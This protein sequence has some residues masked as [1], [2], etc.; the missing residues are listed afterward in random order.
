MTRSTCQP[1]R[2]AFRSRAL[3]RCESNRPPCHV[4]WSTSTAHRASGSHAS[5]WMSDAVAK[6]DRELLDERCNRSFPQCVDDPQLEARPGWTLPVGTL[7][8]HPVDPRRSGAPPSTELAGDGPQRRQDGMMVEHPFGESLEA[9]V[10]EVADRSR[11]TPA[12]GSRHEC[13]RRARRCARTA[14]RSSAG[15]GRRDSA[16]S[17][18]ERRGRSGRPLERRGESPTGWRRRDR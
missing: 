17:D 7:R 6:P 1:I 10:I 12:E 14:A 11:T 8:H 4:T 18:H 5:G 15:V 2:R 13:R 3:S 9:F 16:V